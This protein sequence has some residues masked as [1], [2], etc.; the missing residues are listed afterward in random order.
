MRG[1]WWPE[2][3]FSGID[4]FL[5]VSGLSCVVYM[6][7]AADCLL[8]CKSVF[9]GCHRDGKVDCF[10]IVVEINEYEKP[11]GKHQGKIYPKLQHPCI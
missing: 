8:R 4:F 3:R 7:R 1:K 6:D 9:N 2:H 5:R 11:M 10:A